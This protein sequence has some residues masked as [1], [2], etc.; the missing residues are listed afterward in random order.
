MDATAYG[1]GSRRSMPQSDGGVTWQRIGAYGAGTYDIGWVHPDIQDLHVQGNDVWVATDGGLNYSTDELT[2]HESRK[3][4]IYNTTLWG[5][6]QGWNDGRPVGGTLPQWQ[7]RVFGKTLA[8]G[9]TC[10]SAV[11]RRPTGY[12]NALDANEIRFSDI[13]DLRLPQAFEGTP[14]GHRQ[15]VHVPQRELCGFAIE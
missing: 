1:W 2:T 5:F 3:Y 4:G 14:R 15:P 11:P 13:G 12:V 8:L 7:Y 6:S 9:S 10:G